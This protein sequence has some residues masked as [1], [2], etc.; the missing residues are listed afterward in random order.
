MNYTHATVV[1]ARNSQRPFF[2]ISDFL[3]Q[4][5]Q[6]LL[7][8][9]PFSYPSCPSS[10]SQLDV[11]WPVNGTLLYA[12][13]GGHLSRCHEQTQ[14][15]SPHKVGSSHPT[16]ARKLRP[17]NT[18][19]LRAQPSLSSLGRHWRSIAYPDLVWVW[20]GFRQRGKWPHCAQPWPRRRDHAWTAG[21]WTSYPCVPGVNSLVATRVN[22]Q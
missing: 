21:L 6:P 22:Q 2:Q 7:S 1:S 13:L 18:Q 8:L 9:L 4:L 10:S 3:S 16:R 14:H 19:T 11:I 5:H 20:T 15:W 17:A 12:F